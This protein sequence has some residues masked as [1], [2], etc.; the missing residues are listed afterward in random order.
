MNAVEDFREI[1]AQLRWEHAD[2]VPDP[3]EE[4]ND[5]DD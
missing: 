5:D 2:K 4:D 1:A 3:V